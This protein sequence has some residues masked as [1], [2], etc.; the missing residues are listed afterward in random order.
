[1]STPSNVIDP[2]R[3]AEGTSSCIRLRIRRKVDLPHPEGPMSAVTLPPG[4]GREIRSSTLWEP[5]H[6]LTSVAIRL[7]AVDGA[8]GAVPGAVITGC[9]SVVVTTP[10]RGVSAGVIVFA[11]RRP[12]PTVQPPRQAP[13]RHPVHPSRRAR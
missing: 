3:D 12:T 11:R 7:D 2:E 1:M 10:P 9:C 8:A 5:N 4:M 6:A 13:A